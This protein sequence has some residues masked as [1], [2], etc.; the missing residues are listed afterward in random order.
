MKVSPALEQQYHIIGENAEVM[1]EMEASPALEQ[2]N[3][4]IWVKMLK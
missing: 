3:H 2:Q 1:P 4:I